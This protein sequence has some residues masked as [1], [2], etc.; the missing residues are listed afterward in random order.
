MKK[1]SN[2]PQTQKQIL[3]PAVLS[4]FEERHD[5][6]EIARHVDK[7]PLREL[8]SQVADAL[9]Q[10][11]A[12]AHAGDNEALASYLILARYAVM[13]FDNLVRHEPK[14]MRTITEQSPNFPVLL[15][16]NPQDIEVAKK[17]LRL[18]NVGAK[19]ILPTR[20]GQRTDRSNH[21]TRLAIYAFNTCLENS[22]RIPQI[23]TQRT[24]AKQK[25]V[26]R[27]LWK[28]IEEGTEYTSPNS[29]P[30]VIADWQMQGGDLAGRAKLA[31][32]ITADNFDQ[33]KWVIK[34]CVLE[35]WHRSKNN[36][37]KALKTVGTFGKPEAYRRHLAMNRTLQAFKSQFLRR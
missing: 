14:R 8:E 1:F 6:K 5:V 36:Y 17:R 25:R 37:N 32:Q 27:E 24:G 35:F 22:W 19:A 15:S 18:L 2:A 31:G 23:E 4:L 16:L 13:S 30:I 28:I 20:S 9:K 29:S 11:I 26:K 10:I 12:R 33:W 34:M 21:W 3:Q 7:R